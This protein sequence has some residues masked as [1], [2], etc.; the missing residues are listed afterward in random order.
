[1]GGVCVKCKYCGHELLRIYGKYYQ[2]KLT[3][4]KYPVSEEVFNE[5][6]QA[7]IYHP[8][9]LKTQIIE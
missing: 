4:L 7:G 5:N 1:M 9:C 6:L 3:A 8:E 2:C